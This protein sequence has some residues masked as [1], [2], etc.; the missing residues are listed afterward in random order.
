MYSSSPNTGEDPDGPEDPPDG[1]EGFYDPD[2][3]GIENAP[4]GSGGGSGGSGGGG[5]GGGDSGNSNPCTG[6]AT[7]NCYDNCDTSNPDQADADGDG[8]GDVCDNCPNLANAD[9]DATACEDT[10]GELDCPASE[11]EADGITKKFYIVNDNDSGFSV[12]GASAI[13]LTDRGYLGDRKWTLGVNPE[14]EGFMQF[15]VDN[16]PHSEYEIAMTWDNNTSFTSFQRHDNVEVQIYDGS[17]LEPVKVVYVNQ[18]Q[19]P[20]ADETEAGRK[21]QILETVP[22]FSGEVNIRI[23][24]RGKSAGYSGYRAITADAVRVECVG[25]AE[26]SPQANDSYGPDPCYDP[27]GLPDDFQGMVDKGLDWLR[28]TQVTGGALD[29]SWDP[30]GPSTHGNSRDMDTAYGLIAFVSHGHSAVTPGPYQDA[31]CRAIAYLIRIQ[32][33]NGFWGSDAWWNGACGEEAF[34]N[35]FILYAMSAALAQGNNAINGDCA[36]THTLVIMITENTLM[37][38]I[39]VLR[40]ASINSAMTL[41]ISIAFRRSR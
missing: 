10:G 38:A 30:S 41:R 1:P 32:A 25:G 21:F 12:P 9:Q 16:L 31:V 6:G 27:E 8:V 29:G 2:G 11:Y 28:D 23:M 34:S 37:P 7:E 35:L 33:D 17:G 39:K 5:S 20:T 24:I 3:D 26:Y 36:K 14:A 13:S 22:I 40:I 19:N 18:K 15:Q 4:E